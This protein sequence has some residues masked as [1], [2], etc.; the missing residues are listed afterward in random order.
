M[1]DMVRIVF[2]AFAGFMVGSLAWIIINAL[3]RGEATDERQ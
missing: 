1:I 3:L 2:A